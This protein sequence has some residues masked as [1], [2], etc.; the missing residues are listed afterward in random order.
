MPVL[1]KINTNVIAD[2]AVTAAKIPA[3]A[4]AASEFATGSVSGADIGYLGDGSGNLTGTVSSQ[5][6][7]LADAFTLTGDLTVN[8]N[9]TLGKVRD[10]G[11]GQTLTHTAATN[12]TLTGTG[13]LTM[14][15][16]VEGEPKAGRVTSVDGM[17]G[18]LGSGVTVG[19]E[20]TGSPALNLGN[21]T[22]V[23][24][25]GVTGGSGLDAVN[26]GILHADQWRLTTSFAGDVSPIASNWEQCDTPGQPI[27]N[28]LGTAMGQ[29][30]GV[31]SFP[32]TGIWWVRFNIQVATEGAG[33]SP[34]RTGFG[35]QVTLDN[36]AWSNTLAVGSV[37]MHTT[38]MYNS[39]SCAS[40]VDV[41]NISN[42]KVRF[43]VT[44]VQDDDNDTIG[45]NGINYTWLEFIRLGDT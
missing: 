39:S 10:D 35:I 9:L 41:T 44:Q 32:Q 43:T 40:F 26:A 14:G 19:S 3:G 15:S 23:L 6:L 42:V 5:Q 45:D 36:S 4:V 27:A 12:R 20:V 28:Q 31:F 25:V 7:H 21:F 33:T 11:T 34:G 13:T 22:G 29:S 18:A 2:N 38:A 37:I 8:D 16:S 1:T 30:S 24:P 17:T